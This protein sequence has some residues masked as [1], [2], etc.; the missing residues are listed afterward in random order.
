MVGEVGDPVAFNE[1]GVVAMPV[2]DH[3]AR[4]AVH[5]RAASASIIVARRVSVM[6]RSATDRLG[7]CPIAE[8]HWRQRDMEFSLAKLTCDLGKRDF[9]DI[10]AGRAPR[11]EGA[12]ARYSVL[13]E[14]DRRRADAGDNVI[15]AS[16]HDVYLVKAV[17]RRA[18]P[19]REAASISLNT[20]P[21]RHRHLSLN[22]KRS[23]RDAGGT[24]W[25]EPDWADPYRPA[26]GAE[27][28][29]DPASLASIRRT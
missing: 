26:S 4:F 16:V 7:N 10:N 24:N 17:K 6:Q 12:I 5:A 18:G 28:A 23:C 21:A 2:F 13:V 19:Q 8:I 15:V 3:P 25:P 20:S 29:A 14:P 1:T 9:A 11:L 22:I 27:G